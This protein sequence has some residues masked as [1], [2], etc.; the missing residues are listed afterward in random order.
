MG[1]GVIFV[2]AGCSFLTGLE[3]TDTSRTYNIQI[4]NHYGYELRNISQSGTANELIARRIISYVHS[5]LRIGHTP[6]EIKVLCAWTVWH[7]HNHY[8]ARTNHFDYVSHYNS[9]EAVLLKT[10]NPLLEA[11]RDLSHSVELAY[12]EY[13]YNR[14]AVESYL[15]ERGIEY[16]MT[17][18]RRC[19]QVDMKPKNI[20]TSFITSNLHELFDE[21]KVYPED[22]FDFVK[23]HGYPR[24]ALLH[25]LEE[26]HDAYT[27]V[28]IPFIEKNKIFT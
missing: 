19:P 20:N 3:L 17:H 9:K 22:F 15:R 12:Y 10:G 26:A 11:V 13:A 25:P 5:L 6:E 27:K 4:A 28:L 18:A 24:G 2:T 14:I 16:F 21:T 8:N 7:R 23:R 1:Q